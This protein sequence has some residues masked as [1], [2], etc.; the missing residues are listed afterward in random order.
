M[1]V[2]ILA[3]GKGTRLREITKDAI[4]KP[5]VEI[6]G[7]PILERI[8]SNYKDA[9][10][11]DI[12]LSIGY[13]GNMIKE[14]F[15]DGKRLGV[16][17]QYS[18][19]NEDKISTGGQLLKVKEMVGR[20]RFILGYSDTELEL[21]K[22]DVV[23]TKDYMLSMAGKVV[24]GDLSR[25]GVIETSGS[26]IVDFKEKPNIQ[27]TGIVNVGFYVLHHEV[28]HFMQKH[29]E[30]KEIFSFEQEVIPMILSEYRVGWIDYTGRFKDLGIPKDYL[31]YKKWAEKTEK[32]IG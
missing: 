14:Y 16:N 31:D 5:L 12:I 25:F 22:I 13:K 27:G 3:G 26:E 4:P 7:K 23:S 15:G 21:D 17:I 29:F 6:N 24:D 19:V 2:V 32:M 11:A 8:I 20:E 1:K 10:F 30:T 18:E 28:F 9:G